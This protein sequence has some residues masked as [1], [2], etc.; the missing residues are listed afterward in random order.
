MC[1]VLDIKVETEEEIKKYGI[2]LCNTYDFEN[3]V[4]TRSE[5]GISVIDKN[6]NKSDYPAVKKDVIDVSGAGDTV[7]ATI[8]ILKASNYNMDDICNLANLAAGVVVSKFG[9]ATVSLNEL[10]C[11]ICETGEFKLQKI[12]T[13]KYIVKDLKEKGKKIVFTN[14]CFDLFHVG[15]LHS[16]KEAKKHG[17]ILIVA[18]NS[19]KSVKENKGDLR[20]IINENDRID[21]ICALDCVDYVVLMEDKNPSKL[22]EILQPD[23]SIKGEDWKDKFVPEK[24]VIESYGGHIEFIKLNK[25]HSTTKIIDKVIEVYGKK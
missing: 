18:V 22:I 8:A 2:Q 21:L 19:D 25:G 10:I 14:G 3:L 5:K 7:V 1:D 24:E 16:F 13:L 20:P 9:T 6:G 23:V 11:S 17:D 15:H 4:L 12:E